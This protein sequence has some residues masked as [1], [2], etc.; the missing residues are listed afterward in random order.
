MKARIGTVDELDDLPIF[1]TV[2]DH[3]NKIWQHLPSGGLVASGWATPGVAGVFPVDDVGLPAWLLDDGEG[4]I[5][6]L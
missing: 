5:P 6:G 2:Y 3:D 1:A 4:P